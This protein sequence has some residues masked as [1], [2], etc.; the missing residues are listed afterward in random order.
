MNLCMTCLG[1][2]PKAPG[3]TRLKILALAR[4][5]VL[6]SIVVTVFVRPGFPAREKTT[7]LSSQLLSTFLEPL[8]QSMAMPCQMAACQINERTARSAFEQD[9]A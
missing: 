1:R 2:I 3:S 8:C 6:W 5:R 9:A 7:S 4:Y